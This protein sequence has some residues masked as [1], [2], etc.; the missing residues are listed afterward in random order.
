M[1]ETTQKKV[2]K[3]VAVR[4][5]IALYRA[6]KR[7]LADDEE[8]DKLQPLIVKL[9][10]EYAEYK[11]MAVREEQEE[12]LS[13]EETRL[14]Q[15]FRSSSLDKRRRMLGFIST[16]EE[17]GPEVMSKPKPTK[18]T[19]AQHPTIERKQGHG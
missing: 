19:G 9:L 13:Q 17:L 8:F 3:N 2:P 18:T 12:R 15:E 4:V 1:V 5:D 6:V 11:T 7:R 16:I 14:I 10:T